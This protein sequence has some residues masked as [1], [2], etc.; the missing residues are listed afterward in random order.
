MIYLY[1][2]YTILLRLCVEQEKK[3]Y[4]P[5]TYLPRAFRTRKHCCPSNDKKG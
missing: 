3:Y 4:C 5:L 2:T 1:I